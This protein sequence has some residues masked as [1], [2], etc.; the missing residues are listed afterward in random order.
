MKVYSQ[1]YCL[2]E[3]AGFLEFEDFEFDEA[4]AGIIATANEWKIEGETAEITGF[5]YSEDKERPGEP[6][7]QF[8][9][10]FIYTLNED[11]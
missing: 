7:T 4:A 8:D 5:I 10:I 9:P 1:I 3:E 6:A 11:C 2:E